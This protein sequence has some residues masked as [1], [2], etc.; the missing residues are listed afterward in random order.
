MPFVISRIDGKLHAVLN[1]NTLDGDPLADVDVGSADF[2]G[3][4]VTAR[5]ARRK[6][7][8]IPN[9]IIHYGTRT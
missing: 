2:D 1:V 6:K 9:V 7:G 8:W 3:E 5:L 4:T